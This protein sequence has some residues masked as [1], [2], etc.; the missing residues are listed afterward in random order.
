M[1][2]VFHHFSHKRLRRYPYDFSGRWNMD[3]AAGSV[4]LDFLLWASVGVR[5][6]CEE[7]IRDCCYCN[8]S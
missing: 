5:L 2:G 3:D 7:L 1:Q 4:R 6:T 8:V